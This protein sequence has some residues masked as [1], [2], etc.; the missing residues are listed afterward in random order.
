VAIMVELKNLSKRYKSFFKN[1]D[2]VAVDGIDLQVQQGEILGL[3]GMNGA[4]KTTTIKLICGLLKPTTGSITIDNIDVE[5]RRK[6]VLPKLGAVLEGN[7]NSHWPLTVKENLAYF[8]NLKNMRGKTLKE[9][10]DYLPKYFDLQDKI[11]VPVRLLSQGMRQKVA[12]C[13]ALLS[14]PPLLLLDEPTSNL[15]VQSSRL[16]KDKIQE[17][18]K[19]EGKTVIVTTH[20]MEMAQEVCERVAIV[21]RGKLVALDRVENL[22]EAF[23]EQRYE[24]KIKN[25]I[26][27]EELRKFPSIKEVS[28][29]PD[30]GY[31]TLTLTL[32]ASDAL[33]DIMEFMKKEKAVISAI[34]KKEA[35]LEDIFI[36]F[37]KH[38]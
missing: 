19:R 17:L 31:N 27:W 32:K 22:V 3:L 36:N 10:I 28:F 12:I 37:T 29:Q 11:N 25:G 13:L 35:S 6:D 8:G 38:E 26:C 34:D 33:Y 20:N 9:R 16:I 4:G 18:A 1:Q 15:D 14:D 23:S 5:K 24:F 30:E 21:N 7:R 2:I